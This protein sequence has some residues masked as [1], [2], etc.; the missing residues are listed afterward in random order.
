MEYL[1]DILRIFSENELIAFG[2]IFFV[3][4]VL[5]SFGGV[6]VF[7]LPIQYGWVESDKTGY[8]ISH[9][10]SHC[11]ACNSKLS[12]IELIPILGW[13][14][15][16]GRCKN[17]STSIPFLFP[18]TEFLM[19]LAFVKS[20]LIFGFEPEAL[21]F[22][23]LL[24]FCFVIAWIDWNTE[25]IP[26]MFTTPLLFTGLILSPYH[27]DILNAVYGAFLAW[28]LFVFTFWV[29]AKLKGVEAYSGGDVAFASMVGAWIGMS[30]I[31]EYL[32]VS[33]M[34]FIVF[35]LIQK[36]KKWIPMGP[37]LALAFTIEILLITYG[38]HFFPNI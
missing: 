5:A 3:G 11:D 4:A 14:L 22:C 19:G 26:E 1:S 16:K 36:D 37:A 12:S 24:W 23:M 25:W 6:V 10:P 13:F 27:V 2:F 8:T 30:H 7:R 35:A 28:G 17:C 21:I 18:L 38:I 31:L 34:I 32:F 9:P 15:I 29:V 33:A 20:F